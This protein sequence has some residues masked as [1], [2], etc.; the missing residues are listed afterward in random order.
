MFI[1]RPLG[2]IGT[3]RIFVKGTSRENQQLGHLVEQAHQQAAKSK[4]DLCFDSGDRLDSASAL[5][6]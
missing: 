5:Q 4:L 2:A 6:C 1:C 3:V